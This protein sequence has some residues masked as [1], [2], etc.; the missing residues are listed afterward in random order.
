MPSGIY[1]RSKREKFKRVS[2]F[3]RTTEELK[4][5]I[6]ENDIKLLEL[7]E[8]MKRRNYKKIQKGS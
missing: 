3:H 7:W 2:E 1:K 5:F 6:K 8:Y 4:E